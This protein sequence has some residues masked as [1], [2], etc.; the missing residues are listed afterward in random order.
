MDTGYKRVCHTTFQ[1]LGSYDLTTYFET[2]STNCFDFVSRQS[3]PCDNSKGYKWVP[4]A[5]QPSAFQHG[6]FSQF[7]WFP[8]TRPCYTASCLT[9]VLLPTRGMKDAAGADLRLQGAA[10][11][12][13]DRE[14][15]LRGISRTTNARICNSRMTATNTILQHQA[16]VRHEGRFYRP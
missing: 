7:R 13:V 3:V 15:I 1:G 6:F 16:Y 2:V 11:Q 4:V 12:H 14:E 5:Q 10:L 9:D 8:R